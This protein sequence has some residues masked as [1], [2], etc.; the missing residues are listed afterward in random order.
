MRHCMRLFASAATSAV[1]IVSVAAAGDTGA[2][3]GR[4]LVV[5]L[6]NTGD[7]PHEAMATGILD[8]LAGRTPASPRRALGEALLAVIESDGID[9]AVRRYHELQTKEKALYDFAEPQLNTLG[10]AL[11]GSGNVDAALSIF[12]LN[13]E[14][15]PESGNVYDSLAET[16]VEAGRKEDAIRSYA[17]SLQL[18]P[19]NRNA[20]EQLAKLMATP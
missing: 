19:S 18:D 13:V 9:A 2:E 4:L 11:L 1:L 3:I 15:Y 7:A 8:I 16:Q 5:T 14:A 20:V 10:Y 12:Q 6:N 17:R